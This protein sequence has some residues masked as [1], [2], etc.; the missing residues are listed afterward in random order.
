MLR[1]IG[2]RALRLASTRTVVASAVR[3]LASGHG[4][5]YGGGGADAPATR[6]RAREL[7]EPEEQEEEMVPVDIA[8]ALKSEIALEKVRRAREC[9]AIT[10]CR[11]HSGL[12]PDAVHYSSC[13]GG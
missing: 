11:L 7:V 8:E 2:S 12:I 1:V 6:G 13:C 5:G 3:T 4:G 9:A 10:G